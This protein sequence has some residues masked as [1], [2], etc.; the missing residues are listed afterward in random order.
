MPANKRRRMEDLS[1]APLSLGDLK[2]DC[3]V[4]ILSHLSYEDMN[5]F[6]FTHRRGRDIR[7][8]ESLD[9]TR[10]R[11]IICCKGSFPSCLLSIP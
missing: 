4:H 9:Q 11:T 7:S 6:A 5:N 1:E 3:V 2:D 8:N 10:L